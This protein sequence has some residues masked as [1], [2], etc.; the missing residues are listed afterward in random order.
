VTLVYAVVL[1]AGAGRRMGGRPKA[2]LQIGDRSFLETIVTAARQG[3]V[4][5]V[6][7]VLGH[8][9]EAVEPEARRLADLLCRN[10]DPDRG[11]G[12]SARE[13][14][15]A[16]PDGASMLL[17]PV[18]MPLVSAETVA[19]LLS[20]GR[21]APDRVILPSHS[22]SD[23]GHPTLLPARLLEPVR[24]LADD[25]R[26]DRLVAAEGAPLLVDVDDSGVLRDV[27]EPSDLEKL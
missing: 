17:W 20:A 12:S 5:G 18:D 27:D 9:F 14:A 13:A 23:G 6:A 7:V 2:L 15:R 25:G 1:A 8:H 10:P 22:G 16:L 26:L 19:E 24:S 11:M 3:G 21:T 4:D